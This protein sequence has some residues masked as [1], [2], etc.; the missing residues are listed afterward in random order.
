MN[1]ITNV[2][3]VGG[4][5]FDDKTFQLLMLRFKESFSYSSLS[6]EKA[7]TELHELENKYDEIQNKV[8]TDYYEFSFL[9]EKLRIDRDLR[10]FIVVFGH[11]VGILPGDCG[12]KTPQS[13]ID[14][15]FNENFKYMKN[16]M[17]NAIEIRDGEYSPRDT[18]RRVGEIFSCIFE[19]NA[20][21]NR[22]CSMQKDNLDAFDYAMG[23]NSIGIKEIVK[24]N[25]IVNNSNPNKVSGF[26]RTNNGIR[27]A[28]FNVSDKTSVPT[29]MAELL[30]D[31]D[32][33]FGMEILDPNEKDISSEE[34]DN[35]ILNIFKKEALF[36]IRFERIHPFEDGNGRTGRIIMNKH[37]IDQNMAPVL[38]T[39]IM[40]DEYKEYISTCNCDKLAKMM[41]SSSEQLLST[42]RA[43]SIDV[44]KLKDNSAL[45][46][47]VLDNN[48]KRLR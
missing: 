26:K 5:F 13:I 15:E 10:R 1:K 22:A 46:L 31:Y 27:G 39:N 48:K 19:I 4:S 42:W 11:V 16:Y 47:C 14:K 18:Y 29:Q 32:D 45:A 40:S 2:H 17:H 3:R 12:L 25:D 9:S 38:I 36:H 28:K 33:N 21:E 44:K 41:F 6:I 24:I 23:L 20:A 37:L 30:A 35:R 43:S 34:R 7:F 8:S